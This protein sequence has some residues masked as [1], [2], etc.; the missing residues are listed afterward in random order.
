[1][2]ERMSL[3]VQ[4]REKKLLVQSLPFLYEAKVIKNFSREGF[5]SV[6]HAGRKPWGIWKREARQNPWRSF[7]KR[8]ARRNP[9]RSFWKREGEKLVRERGRVRAGDKMLKFPSAR[10]DKNSLSLLFFI[11]SL[12]RGTRNETTGENAVSLV[13]LSFLSLPSSSLIEKC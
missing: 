4:S 11:H 2:I 9:W 1:M 13:I 12:A 7:W 8:E 6:R 5:G 10:S 3:L